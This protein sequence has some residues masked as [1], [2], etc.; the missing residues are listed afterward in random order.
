MSIRDTGRIPGQTNKEKS[1]PKNQNEQD[2][3]ATSEDEDYIRKVRVE[4][5]QCVLA[6]LF[7]RSK[8][9]QNPRTAKKKNM[10]NN[11]ILMDSQDP[12]K[13][14]STIH[15][16]YE[17]QEF[18]KMPTALAAHLVPKIRIF[19][20][21]KNNNKSEYMFNYSD[22]TANNVLTSQSGYKSISEKKGVDAGILGVKIND[23]SSQPAEE[24][25]N[26]DVSIQLFFKNLGL[27]ATKKATVDGR[28]TYSDLVKRQSKSFE[29]YD[30]LNNQ[31]MLHVG[32]QLP[33]TS[34]TAQDLNISPARFTAIKK[35]ILKSVRVYRLHLQQHTFN[36][37]QDG[38]VEL[39]ISYAAAI[40][41]IANDPRTDLML[42]A[43]QQKRVAQ[44]K[45]NISRLQATVKK[46]KENDKEKEDKSTFDK[47]AD[48]FS[49]DDYGD[50]EGFSEDEKALAQQRRELQKITNNAQDEAMSRFLDELFGLE[51]GT[52]SYIKKITVP[53]ALLG[54]INQEENLKTRSYKKFS[55]ESCGTYNK[56]L[57]A[58]EI[59]SSA[60]DPNYQ[61]K[62]DAAKNLKQA[63]KRAKDSAK[64]DSR[65]VQK[66]DS[67]SSRGKDLTELANGDFGIKSS[68]GADNSESKKNA[69]DLVNKVLGKGSNLDKNFYDVTFFHYGDLLEVAL[70][71]MR[72][73]GSPFDEAYVKTG[74][75]DL[76]PTPILGP[77]LMREQSCGGEVILR[78][79]ANI[80]DVPISVDF[81]IDFMTAKFIKPAR[82]NLLFK[83]FV[84]ELNK[85]IL[86][87]ALGETC[88]LESSGQGIQ[89][90]HSIPVTLKKHGAA[91][92]LLGRPF[93]DTGNRNTSYISETD[94]KNRMS[95]V[96][97]TSG[98][99]GQQTT[100][101]YMLIYVPNYAFNN[102]TGNRARDLGSGIYHLQAGEAQSIIKNFSI[103]ANSQP[104]MA[105]AM[106]FPEGGKPQL[107]RD[108]AGDARY[109]LNLEMLGHT[110][111]RVGMP[112]YFDVTALGIGSAA[113]IKSLAHR[114]GIGGY[115]HVNSL[116]YVITPSEF[117]VNVHSMFLGNQNS[118]PARQQEQGKVEP[119]EEPG[120]FE[121]AIGILME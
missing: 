94:A 39:D 9:V 17:A 47:L 114:M 23:K 18:F 67:R 86:P 88:R 30:P 71:I 120:F 27:F 82:S 105:E 8:T 37:A 116:D 5:A 73:P 55:S 58:V 63:I 59:A 85:T 46:E 97:S 10:Y 60:Q 4:H 103:D 98:P 43:N 36:F 61:G 52:P 80:A 118:L 6:S 91:D 113:N 53:G 99:T 64:F 107:G 75:I 68:Q 38:S 104:Y 41:G 78:P 89:Y 112:F 20:V 42:S 31:I 109:D 62:T 66:K 69:S 45:A 81:F 72:R 28:Y 48:L 70:K 106:A 56:L 100:K 22:Y 32:Y 33:E 121:Q 26:L 79:G 2:K 93:V 87:G 51:K 74:L 29:S 44:L 110:F 96:A 54:A 115:Y 101:E 95:Y 13:M 12:S 16:I 76:F 119:A 117:Y 77:M 83:E 111:F 11:F 14:I 19:A 50:T 34:I 84:S 35:A 57:K 25:K 65:G 15:G 92:Q 24:G 108:I 90:A 1:K 21:D 49:S 7:G 102:L 40:D 3:L